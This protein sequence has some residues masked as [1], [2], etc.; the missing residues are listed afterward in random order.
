LLDDEPQADSSGTDRK[1][2]LPGQSRNL[3]EKGE[4]LDKETDSE[5]DDGHG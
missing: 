5:F 1:K 2:G 4:E 3:P